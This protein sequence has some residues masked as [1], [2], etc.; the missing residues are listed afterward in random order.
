MIGKEK[1]GSW[2]RHSGFGP[3]DRPGMTMVVASGEASYFAF[4]IFVTV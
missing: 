1:R 3:M 4:C 2:T